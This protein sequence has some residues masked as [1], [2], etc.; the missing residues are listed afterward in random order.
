MLASP[1]FRKNFPFLGAAQAKAAAKQKRG[2]GKC[3]RKNRA[4]QTD[5]AGVRKQIGLLS[6]DQKAKLKRMLGATQVQVDYINGAKR[7]IRLK[8]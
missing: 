3:G 7:K 4:V 1:A 2:C 6:V 8:F 5:Y